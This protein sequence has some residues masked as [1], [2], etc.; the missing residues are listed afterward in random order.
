MRTSSAFEH[1]LLELIDEPLKHAGYYI[2][3]LKLADEHK[4]KTLALTAER[5]DGESMGVADCEAIST[6]ASALFDVDDPIE[7]A[8][9]LE[10]SSPGMERPLTV[11]RDF[12]RYNGQVASIELNIAQNGRKRFKGKLAGVSDDKVSIEVDGEKYS[13]P[14]SAM[15]SAALVATDEMIRELLAAQDLQDQGS[16][17]FGKKKQRSN[18][19]AVAKTKEETKEKT[20]TN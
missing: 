9:D 12:E 15:R 3:Q 10:V 4:K 13:L 14:F 16:R 7:A 6:T 11:I 19:E 1:T 17:R 18:S 8:Y 20:V 5:V 2:V